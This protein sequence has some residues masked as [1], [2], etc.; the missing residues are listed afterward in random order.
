MRQFQIF[1]YGAFLHTEHL[2]FWQAGNR[3]ESNV[4]CPMNLD[5]K[6]FANYEQ[7]GVS[8]YI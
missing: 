6:G 4:L 2:D 7:R 5:K 8:S 1:F 3:H